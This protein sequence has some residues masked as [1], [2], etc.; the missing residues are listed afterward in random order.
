VNSTDFA[1]VL[2][3]PRSDS[4]E[5]L[6][7]LR[8]DLEQIDYK[9]DA[10]FGLLGEEAME[11][12]A[13]DQIPAALRRLR[14]AGADN[15]RLATAIGLF[16]LGQVR[17][18]AAI[19]AAFA[20]LG[21]DGLRQ[22]GLLE[23]HQAGLRASVALVPHSSDDTEEL[24]VA[25]DLGAHQR[26]GVLRADHVLGIGQ[27]SLTLA[28]I[29]LRP[30]V[31][32]ALDL[33]T[34]CGIQ[35]FH[36]LAH[37][38]HVTA[39]DLSER[40]LAFTRFNLLLNHRQLRLEPANLDARVTLRQ[41]SLFEPVEDERFELIVPNPPFVITPRHPDQDEVFTY[42]DAGMAG[43]ELVRTL[44]EQLPEHL[45][46]GGS[47]QMLANWEIPAAGGE[48]AW[49]ERISP[50][51]DPELDVWVIQREQSTPSLYAETWL[52]DASQNE[53]LPAYQREYDAY[54]D[55]FASRGVGAVGFGY[56]YA[57][58]PG[59][60]RA[61]ERRFESIEHQVE[62]PLAP[63]LQ[64]DLD[65]LAE[66]RQAGEQWRHWH[67]V[68]AEDVTEERHQRPG[69]EHP[70][71]ILLRQGAG[72]RRT[73][74][75]DTAQAGFVSACDGELTVTQLVNA[76]DSLIG[77]G[78]ADFGDRLLSGIQRLIRHG[79]LRKV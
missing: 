20:H 70:G 24:W 45:T 26:P 18:Q 67:L 28:R 56:V 3:A 53:D 34:G 58:R 55:D 68:P 12:F 23:A 15:P 60:P 32:R 17:E 38:R 77:E 4:Q 61:A 47:A 75:L 13:R 11:A 36:L 71:V 8:D 29:T 57:G 52:R 69:A 14:G 42:R 54:L 72:L 9:Y 76:L 35:L 43:D 79:F 7:A 73:E 63:Y 31:D 39:T 33:G 37:S 2:D 21:S 19:D 41:G 66:L 64:R 10:I 6:D 22:L 40:A 5:L 49:H 62:Q 1:A 16:L 78:A 50:W 74:L 30:H 25:H 65:T 44:I 51:F 59:T 46:P 48:G 27:A